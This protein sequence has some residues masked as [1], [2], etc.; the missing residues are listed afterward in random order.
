VKDQKQSHDDESIS[1]GDI[2]PEDLEIGFH[3][4]RTYRRSRRCR[5]HLAFNPKPDQTEN[6]KHNSKILHVV[7]PFILRLEATMLHIA[8]NPNDCPGEDQ[9]NP[10]PDVR[11]FRKSLCYAKKRHFPSY[12]Q[13]LEAWSGWFNSSESRFFRYLFRCEMEEKPDQ[14]TN[15]RE[16][17]Y[18][19]VFHGFSPFFIFSALC[20]ANCRLK[21]NA[22]KL[23]VG[24]WITS[25]NLHF[26]RCPDCNEQQTKPKYAPLHFPA[27]AI[28]D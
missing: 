26:P 15:D 11:S 17:D 24:T 8:I 5:L 3:H 16:Y 13:F 22:I 18:R 27:P 4:P 10:N 6:E 21:T 14:K 12:I 28:R 20:F 25:S 9:H 7:S 1:R 19:P 23:S 2:R